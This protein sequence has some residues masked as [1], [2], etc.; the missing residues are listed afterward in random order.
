MEKVLELKDVSVFNGST[1]I[2]NKINLVIYQHQQWAIIGPSGS[3]KTTLAHALTG[4]IAHHGEII[5]YA[6]KGITAFVEQQHHFKNLSNTSEF[7]YQQRFNAADAGDSMTVADALHTDTDTHSWIERLHL[8]PLLNKPLIQLS[9]GENK[10]LQLA[11]ALLT[12]PGFIIFDNPFTGL[13]SEG[14]NSL[15]N[16]INDICAAGIQALIITSPAD[17]PAAI[18]HVALLEN[19]SLIA[20]GEKETI[21]KRNVSAHKAAHLFKAFKPPAPADFEIAVKMTDVTIR[22]GEKV[23]LNQINWLVKKGDCWRLSGANGAGKSTL[24]SLI[25]G[26]NPQA[27][28]NE[29]YLFDKRRGTGE[30]IWDIKRNIGYISPELHLHF[31]QFSTCFEAVAS[32]LFDTIGLFRRLNKEQE[33]TTL[34][35]MEIMQLEPLKNKL[36]RQLSTGQQRMVLLARAMVKQPPLLILD[37]PCQG[38]DKQQVEEI[39]QLID[40]MHHAFGTTVIY[41]S[42]YD[43]DLPSCVDKRL[44]LN[45]GNMQL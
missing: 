43:D 19:G 12:N 3:G 24:L 21:N 38:L 29:V 15:H 11:R 30:S 16:I 18:T 8:L 37:E 41:V 36:L 45:N 25:T 9:N 23:I 13:D 17:L 32:G 6:S 44:T 31:D 40:D 39:K 1:P 27:Y 7:Y 2:L 14:R 10:R 42:H 20:E 28:A 26:D 35:W 33:E 34:R 5:Y 22:Y 4:R